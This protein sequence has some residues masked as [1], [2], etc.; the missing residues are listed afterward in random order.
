MIKRGATIVNIYEKYIIYAL[1]R[2]LVPGFEIWQIIRTEVKN[3][4]MLNL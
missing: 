2:L 1:M 4:Y 3:L